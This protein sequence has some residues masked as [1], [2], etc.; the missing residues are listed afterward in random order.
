MPRSE[1]GPAPRVVA[2]EAV[3]PRFDRYNL[4]HGYNKAINRRQFSANDMLDL[5]AD[6]WVYPH[7]TY[8]DHPRSG[9]GRHVPMQ[10]THAQGEKPMTTPWCGCPKSGPCLWA[11]CSS[12]SSPTRA[13]PRKCSDIPLNGP[14]LCDE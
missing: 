5:F 9:G 8:A 4:T 10:L 13:T 2:H 6:D 12:G 3:G 14:P 11:T 7:T 1:E